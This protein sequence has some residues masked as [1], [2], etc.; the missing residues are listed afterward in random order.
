MSK[1]DSPKE[2]KQLYA[3]NYDT[4]ERNQRRHKQ[5]ERYFMFLGRK[6]W[7]C[8]NAYTTKHNHRFNVIPVKLPVAFFTEQNKKFHNSYGNTKDAK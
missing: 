6:N 2:T 4:S 7:Y 1:I 5:M 8:E 3:E